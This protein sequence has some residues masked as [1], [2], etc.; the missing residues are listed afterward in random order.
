MNGFNEGVKLGVGAVRA[1]H[2][3]PLRCEDAVTPEC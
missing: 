1:G 2:V 3:C